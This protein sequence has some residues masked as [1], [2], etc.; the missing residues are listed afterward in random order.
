MSN[1][2]FNHHDLIL[3][4]PEFD[5]DLMDFIIELDKLR[6]IRL[7]GSTPPSIFYE[8]K[9][10]FHLME[11]VGSARIEGN[12]TTMAAYIEETRLPVS[13]MPQSI[14]EINNIE[15][16]IQ[17]VESNINESKINRHFIS[18][19]H[20]MV[21]K[22]L[23]HTEQWVT[24]PGEY[25]KHQVRIE[26]SSHTPPDAF[27]ISAYMD[28]LFDFINREDKSRY[29]LLK[30][31]I[32]HHRFAWIHPF[33]DGNGRTVRLLTYAML[34]KKGFNVNSIINPTAVFCSDRD[35]YYDHLSKAD[36]GSNEGMNAWC[37]YVLIGLKKEFDKI[38]KLLDYEY[39]K[40]E[41]LIPS[42][43]HAQKHQYITMM[44]RQILNIAIQKI[45]IKSLDILPLMPGSR[46]EQRSRM[47]GRLIDEKHVLKSIQTNGR[48]YVMD[49]K[50][51]NLIRSVVWALGM[52]GFLPKQ[53]IEDLQ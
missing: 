4:K 53:D 11:S 17:F 50:N 15:H 40:N 25:R 5:S 2:K 43:S 39:V 22:D 19:I 51:G 26:K 12:N 1:K 34:L 52:K 21:L 27:Q 35:A 18:E 38:N 49:F 47:I 45:T 48:K 36:S 37:L 14:R 42:I 29:D 24:L 3:I 28:E 32:A 46:S 33:G 31:A 30:V 16:A 6:D 20:K 7:T 8:L 44:D 9:H 23:S 13:G 41:I 10:I